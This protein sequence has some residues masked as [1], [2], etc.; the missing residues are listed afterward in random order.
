MRMEVKASQEE[1]SPLKMI[2][3]SLQTSSGSQRISDMMLLPNFAGKNLSRVTL[4]RPWVAV[5]HLVLFVLD[6]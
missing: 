5:S 6:Y 4:R 1:T 2:S 3:L